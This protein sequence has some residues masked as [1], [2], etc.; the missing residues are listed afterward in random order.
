MAKRGLSQ[1]EKLR[2][3]REKEAERR[4]KA[5]QQEKAR[6]EKERQREQERRRREK[7]KRKHKRAQINTRKKLAIAVKAL[8]EERERKARAERVKSARKAVLAAVERKVK[9]AE[10]RVAALQSLLLRSRPRLPGRREQFQAAVTRYQ[11]VSATMADNAS[12]IPVREEV[13]VVRDPLAATRE[14]YGKYT[15]KGEIRTSQPGMSVVMEGKRSVVEYRIPIGEMLSEMTIEEALYK[16]QEALAQVSKW[17]TH[18]Y[19]NIHLYQSEPTYEST[20]EKQKKGGSPDGWIKEE[21]DG[22]TLWS[23][24]QGV[25][26]TPADQA[27]VNNLQAKLEGIID[28]HGK[29]SVSILHEII[30]RGLNEDEIDYKK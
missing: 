1:A 28:S 5:A 16:A 7:E 23:T 27:F 6:R 21:P 29:R 26:T 8:R 30:I 24:W 13:R 22:N 15:E 14:M 10:E 17:K 9:K 25:K 3:E 20:S 4:K 2:R 19:S 18:V 12:S 11:R